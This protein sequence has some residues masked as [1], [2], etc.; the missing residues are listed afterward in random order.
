MRDKSV[1]YVERKDVINTTETE[2]ILF[3]S[4][5]TDPIHY[6]DNEITQCLH[7]EIKN[8]KKRKVEK[9]HFEWEI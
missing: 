4:M 9:K 8:L 5:L 1:Y 6:Y 2:S 7:T 3:S